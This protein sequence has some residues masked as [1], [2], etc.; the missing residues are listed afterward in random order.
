[1]NRHEARVLGERM[2]QP[3]PDTSIV[4]ENVRLAGRVARLEA[5][6]LECLEYVKARHETRLASMIEETLYGRPV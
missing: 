5:D 3:K 2:G 1:M 6:L 4:L